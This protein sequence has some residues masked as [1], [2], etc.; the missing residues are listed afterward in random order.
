MF[1]Y[2]KK[3]FTSNNYKNKIETTFL[4]YHVLARTSTLITHFNFFYV[5]IS[6]KIDPFNDAKK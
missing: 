5:C 1:F 2:I 4:Q 3:L 6:D